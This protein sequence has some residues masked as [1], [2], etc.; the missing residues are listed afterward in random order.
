MVTKGRRPSRYCTA[1][2]LTRAKPGASAGPRP[3]QA[4]VQVTGGWAGRDAELVAEGDV[5]A[6]RERLHQ[7][8]VPALT[9]RRPCHQLPRAAL[10]GC[11]FRAAHAQRRARVRLQRAQVQGVKLSPDIGD[12][13]Q[14]VAGQEPAP[15][16]EQG[17]LRGAPGPAGSPRTIADSAR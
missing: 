1:L 10:G 8:P 9:E 6:L 2:A 17:D 13:R 11:Q 4:G 14:V 16:G 15:G 12:P 5:A 3:Q 7:D